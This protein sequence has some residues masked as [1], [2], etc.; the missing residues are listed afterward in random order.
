MSH[1]KATDFFW[2]ALDFKDYTDL[3]FGEKQTTKIWKYTTA[4]TTQY[5]TT[6]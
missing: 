4:T 6:P 3:D 2:F 5:K 1:E